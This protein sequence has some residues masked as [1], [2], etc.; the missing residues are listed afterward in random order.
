MPCTLTIL[1]YKNHSVY[2]TLHLWRSADG[3]IRAVLEQENLNPQPALMDRA[4][5]ELLR[6]KDKY[7]FKNEA[8]HHHEGFEEQQGENRVRRLGFRV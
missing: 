2:G 7:F 1:R 8:H 6:L 5:D 4:M 3:T